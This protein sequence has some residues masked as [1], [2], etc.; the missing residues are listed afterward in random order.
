MDFNVLGPLQVA[1]GGRTVALGGPRQRAVLALLLLEPNRVV[2]MDRLLDRLWGDDPPARAT[3]TVQAYVSNLRRALEPQ[4]R[5]GEPYA[6]AFVHS[7]HA[8]LATLARDREAAVAAATRAIAL[9]EQHGFPL[10]AWHAALPLGWAQ[11]GQGEPAAGLAAIDHGLS[12]L[13]RCGQRILM[14]FHRGLQAEVLLAL[15]EAGAALALLD[16][17]LAETAARGGGFATPSLHH[18]RGLALAQRGALS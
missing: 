17:A 15:D 7:F 6:E 12:A 13:Q 3:G 8:R 1:D 4:R 9:A 10:L 16:E 14:P 5:S 18:L 2:S 11:A